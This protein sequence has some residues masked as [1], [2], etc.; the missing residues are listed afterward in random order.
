[1]SICIYAYVFVFIFGEYIQ[2]D[3]LEKD[4]YKYE[5]SRLCTG[6]KNLFHYPVI[7]LSSFLESF[8][9]MTCRICTN[10]T[11]SITVTIIIS[12]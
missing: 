11:K 4:A 8:V 7:L 1:M 5:K 12:A 6:S 3:L 10:A 2:A 9:P